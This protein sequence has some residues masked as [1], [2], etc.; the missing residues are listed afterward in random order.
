MDNPVKKIL[1]IYRVKHDITN[2]EIADSLD[3]STSSI[4]KIESGFSTISSIRYLKYLR[5][6]GVDLNSL[7]DDIN[8]GK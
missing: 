7:F 6:K 2:K 3:L 4:S 8:K 5:S 1:R